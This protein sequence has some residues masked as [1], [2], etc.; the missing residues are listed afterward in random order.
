[1]TAVE[2]ELLPLCVM[3]LPSV[4]VKWELS[5]QMIQLLIDEIEVYLSPAQINIVRPY[6][7]AMQR[8]FSNP[9]MKAGL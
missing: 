5:K 8:L 7:Q 3:V 6:T 2:Y 9:D 1:M 4:E